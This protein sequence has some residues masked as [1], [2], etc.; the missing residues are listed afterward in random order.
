MASLGARPLPSTT[1]EC[2]KCRYA[3]ALLR[4]AIF[5]PVGM[6]FAL[7]V[8]WLVERVPVLGIVLAALSMLLLART[9]LMLF[10]RPSPAKALMH[11]ALSIGLGLLIAGLLGLVLG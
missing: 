5:I 9:L 8:S 6:V 1:D 4:A 2:R 3:R 11:I 10:F 7:A